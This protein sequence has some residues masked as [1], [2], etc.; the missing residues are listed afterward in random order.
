M[1][2][3]EKKEFLFILISILRG[4]FEAQ[5]LTAILLFCKKNSYKENLNNRFKN[6]KRQ[7]YFLEITGE[8]LY[9]SKVSGKVSKIYPYTN[10][11]TIL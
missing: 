10:F 1:F 8:W 3:G 4:K 11:H 2:L 7:Y 9:L 6:K 5:N